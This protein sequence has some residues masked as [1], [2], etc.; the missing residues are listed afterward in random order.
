MKWAPQGRVI[1]GTELAELVGISKSKVS[2][3]LCGERTTVT[4]ETA[5]RIAEA[6]GVHQGALFFEPLSTPMGVDS[7]TRKDTPHGHERALH[8]NA[9]R[10][11]Q[12]L[13][14]HPRQGEPYRSR[15]PR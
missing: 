10:R 3:L 14:Q 1:S 5:R 9:P 13:V 7:P 15:P 8:A 4:P 2:A 6:L 12:E 11:A